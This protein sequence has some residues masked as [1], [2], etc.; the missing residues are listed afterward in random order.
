[1]TPRAVC[2]GDNCIDYYLPPIERRFVGGNAVNVAVHL[3]RGGVP[4]S[5]VGVV[6]D[7]EAGQFILD[8][9]RAEALDVSHIR[10]MKG[11]TGTTEIKVTNEGDRAFICEDMGVQNEL[12]LDEETLDFIARHDLVH[13]TLLGRTERYLVT[14]KQ[15]ELLVS[16][17]YSERY[18]ERLL[19][20]TIGQVDI[21]FFST[22]GWSEG[23][24]QALACQMY[25]QGPHLVVVTRGQAGSL[26]YNGV[27]FYTQPAILPANLVDTLGAGDTFIGRFLAAHL[28]GRPLP[29]CLREA[30]EVAAQTCTHL[31]AWHGAQFGKQKT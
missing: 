7:D 23:Q 28:H 22:P 18:T 8:R 25:E 26:A 2:V 14:F 12:V 30:T 1:M 31:G 10:V 3:Q 9:L 19:D 4:T 16:F 24:V 29:D 21:A 15:Q 6:G 27:R 11:P 13:N 17:D 20:E 5:Y